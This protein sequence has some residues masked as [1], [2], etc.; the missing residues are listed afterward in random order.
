MSKPIRRAIAAVAMTA[1]V[2]ASACSTGGSTA[3][4]PD[5]PPTSTTTIALAPSPSAAPTSTTQPSPVDTLDQAL[6]AIILETG[7]PALGAAIFD[8]TGQI[9]GAVAGVRARGGD[10]AATVDDLFHLGSNTKAMTAALLARLGEQDDVLSLDTTLAEAFPT[11]AGLHSDYSAVSLGQ[12]LSHTGGVPG[13]DDIDVDESIFDLPAADGRAI[14]TQLVLSQP[15]ITAPGTVSSYSNSGY[16]IVAAAMEAATGR[17]WEDLMT[18]EVFT[19]LGMETCG[20]GPP[21]IKG[22]TT[23][24]LGHDAAT[25]EPVY[26]DNA[27]LFAPAGGVHCSMADWGRF[28][29]EL[30]RGSS[31]DSDFLTQASI[32]RLFEP[33]P[34]PVDGF[35]DGHAAAGWLVV[36][37]PQGPVLLHD[38]SNT[39][40]YSQAAIVPEIGRV[41]VAVSNEESTGEQAVALTFAALTELHPA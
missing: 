5:L 12:L 39:A 22:D 27:V 29:V 40:W 13:D 11:V 19:P 30:L 6:G 8:R 3:A 16:V 7:V 26:W 32:E 2:A 34:A 15:P 18:E 25:G 9:D 31:G 36:D 21:G 4:P 24:P 1:A 20:F 23:Q 41:V 17:S 37:G 33:S 14:G 28:L 35:P 38:G 10:N